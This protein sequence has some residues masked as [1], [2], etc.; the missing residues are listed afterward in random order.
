MA[1]TRTGSVYEGLARQGDPAAIPRACSVRAY[2]LWQIEWPRRTVAPALWHSVPA[3]AV[4]PP[5]GRAGRFDAP[6]ALYRP[7]AGTP[8]SEGNHTRRRVGARAD[9]G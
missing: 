6:I 2:A 4:E 1:E 8:A 3:M 7:N 9:T 5:A